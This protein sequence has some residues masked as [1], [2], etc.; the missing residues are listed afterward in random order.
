MQLRN[1]KVE[2][3]VTGSKLWQGH[4]FLKSTIQLSTIIDPCI[5]VNVGCCYSDNWKLDFKRL[6]T[7]VLMHVKL[8]YLWLHKIKGW[9]CMCQKGKENVWVEGEIL[10]S[11][12]SIG[13][14]EYLGIWGRVQE[15]GCRLPCPL[16]GNLS[17]SCWMWSPSRGSACPF[18][19]GH[20]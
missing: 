18:C 2:G 7:V 19:L 12:E 8:F 15:Q 6:K 13:S 11:L 5:S 16:C 3:T 20:L 14:F 1:S 10:Q 9:I 4:I 17:P